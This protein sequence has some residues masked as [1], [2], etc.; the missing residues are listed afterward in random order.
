MMKLMDNTKRCKTKGMKF[1]FLHLD[2]ICFE[3]RERVQRCNHIQNVIKFRFMEEAKEDED[4][5]VL[6][7]NVNK[8]CTKL[9]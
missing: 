6:L 9:E 5:I 8:L 4:M 3:H 1:L 7:Q 2:P